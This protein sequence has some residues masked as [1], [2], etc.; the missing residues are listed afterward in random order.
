LTIDGAGLGGF[1]DPLIMAKLVDLR[2]AVDLRVAAAAAPP[3]ARPRVPGGQCYYIVN[4]DT[5]FTIFMAKIATF[6]TIFYG[7]NAIQDSKLQP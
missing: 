7:K 2:E 3:A 4:M 5:F 6:F 1:L